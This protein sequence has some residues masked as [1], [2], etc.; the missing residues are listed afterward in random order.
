[1]LSNSTSFSPDFNISLFFII[2]VCYDNHKFYRFRE[3]LCVLGILDKMMTLPELFKSAFCSTPTKL[4]ADAVDSLFKVEREEKE[5]N[6]WKREGQVL[7]S[8][9]DYLQ[10]AEGIRFLH[11]IDL[12]QTNVVHTDIAIKENYIV[13]SSKPIT[14]GQYMLH[15][16]AYTNVT[17]LPIGRYL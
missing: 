17:S 10:D 15:E 4:T 8:W 6:K 7:S 2:Y 5:S 11:I 3:G 14:T 13:L 9:M 16:A 1:M 12:N